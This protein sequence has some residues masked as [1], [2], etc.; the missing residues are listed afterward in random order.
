MKAKRLRAILSTKI[1][2]KGWRPSVPQKRPTKIRYIFDTKIYRKKTVL[3]SFPKNTF[4]KRFF[5]DFSIK[6]VETL[7]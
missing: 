2:W 6:K 7:K 3:K 4:R 5:E 1:I